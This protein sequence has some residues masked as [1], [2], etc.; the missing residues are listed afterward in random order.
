[1][2]ERADPAIVRLEG[3]HDITTRHDVRMAFQ[4]VRDNP[5]LIVDLTGVR[6]VDSTMI[7][8]LFRAERRTRSLEGKFV[9]IARNQRMVRLLSIAG[10]T[11][12]A[13][14]VDTL[15]AAVKLIRAG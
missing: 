6:Y 3:E 10:L 2:N 15:E 13:P 5:R 8:E 7:E 9:M 12:S 4:K 14:I 1:V 11:Q